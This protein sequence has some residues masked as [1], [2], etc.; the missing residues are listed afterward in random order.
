MSYSDVIILRKACL[1][2]AEREKRMQFWVRLSIFPPKSYVKLKI[3][4]IQS[5]YLL[6]THCLPPCPQQRGQCLNPRPYTFEW[7]KT[8][9]DE[10]M[11]VL[12]KNCDV[13]REIGRK[14]WRQVTVELRFVVENGHL[15]LAVNEFTSLI[16]MKLCRLLSCKTTDPGV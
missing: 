11:N 2:P 9:I 8:G 6:S 3:H 10:L 5:S 14:L 16:N 4:P 7:Q 15:T 12:L 1:V 13:G